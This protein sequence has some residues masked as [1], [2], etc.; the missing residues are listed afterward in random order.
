MRAAS[1]CEISLSWSVN[2]AVPKSVCYE[3]GAYKFEVV[4]LIDEEVIRFQVAMSD[5]QFF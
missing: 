2:L 3:G 5:V 4:V 1:V